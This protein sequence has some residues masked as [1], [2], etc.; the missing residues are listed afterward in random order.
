MPMPE[1]VL[2]CETRDGIAFVTLNRPD[3]H[4]ALNQDL[5]RRVAET[6]G[7]I[8]SDDE[9]RAVVVSGAG[10]RAF[11]AGADITEFD[12]QQGPGADDTLIGGHRWHEAPARCAKPVIAAIQGY[13]F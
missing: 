2:I 9:V 4:N 11:S 3:T 5:R 10:D 13:C 6:F 7:T 8:A 12:H 1:D